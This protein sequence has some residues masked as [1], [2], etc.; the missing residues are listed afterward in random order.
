MYLKEWDGIPYMTAMSAA[1]RDF[2]AFHSNCAERDEPSH[3]EV[4]RI[5]PKEARNNSDTNR[6]ESYV[7]QRFPNGSMYHKTVTTE[8]GKRFE[9]NLNPIGNV[10]NP[11]GAAKKTLIKWTKTT[12]YEEFKNPNYTDIPQK[13]TNTALDSFLGFLFFCMVIAGIILIILAATGKI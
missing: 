3:N 10:R 1:K 4:Y 8:N 11:N 2:Y 5:S 7:I 12:I 6:N 9:P 13:K